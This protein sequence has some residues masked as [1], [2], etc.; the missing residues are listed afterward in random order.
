MFKMQTSLI[1]CFLKFAILKVG[2]N[3]PEN[4]SLYSIPRLSRT[5]SIKISILVV[6]RLICYSGL[7]FFFAT[8]SLKGSEKTPRMMFCL[9]NVVSFSKS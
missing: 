9:L 2:S 6:N 7:Y 4:P 1:N 5:V 8:A 3:L